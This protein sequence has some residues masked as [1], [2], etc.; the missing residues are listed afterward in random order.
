M[1][2]DIHIDYMISGCKEHDRKAQ[3]QLYLYFYDSMMNL[4]MRYTKS[5]T[6]A[7]HVLHD[8]FLR[9]F[10]NIHQFDSSKGSLYTWIYKIVMN[11]CLSHIKTKQKTPVNNEVE[12]AE[13]VYISPEIDNK[14]NEQEILGLIRDLPEATQAVFNLFIIDGYGHKEIAQLLGISEGTS[15]WHLNEGRRRLKNLLLQNSKQ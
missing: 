3:E 11:C 9:V 15:K 10:K 13:E 4:C 6:D 14:L 5:E 7:E 12:E 2:T 8:G 1:V